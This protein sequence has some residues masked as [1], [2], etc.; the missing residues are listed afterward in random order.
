MGDNG[1]TSSGETEA[2]TFPRGEQEKER[3]ETQHSLFVSIAGGLI[4]ESVPKSEIQRVADIAAGTGIWL[5]DVARELNNPNNRYDGF[6]ISDLQFPS[7]VPT[8]LGS[9]N[10]TVHDMTKRFP[11]E[12]YGKYDLVNVRFVVQALKG[13]LVPTVIS[14][15]MELLRPGG[16]LQWHDAQWDDFRAIPPNEDIDYVNGIFINHMKAYGLSGRLPEQVEYGMKEIG[17]EDVVSKWVHTNE[18]E[19]QPR[20][21]LQTRTGALAMMPKA[22]ETLALQEG[23][24]VDADAIRE[25]I[26]EV[27]GRIDRANRNGHNWDLAYVVVVGRKPT[28]DE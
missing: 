4:D 6:D 11:E 22:L 9:I 3:L 7:E 17:F 27:E 26:K 10:F 13:V 12:Y 23:K 19:F 14:H 18:T 24:T 25:K 16:Y 1:A 15:L 8:G 2:Y 28:Q 20:I 21:N 5:F